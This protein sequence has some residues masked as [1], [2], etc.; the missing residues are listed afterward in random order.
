[1][2]REELLTTADVYKEKIRAYKGE[3]KE[4]IHT[5][6]IP[7]G[8][9]SEAYQYMLEQAQSSK[10]EITEALLKNFYGLCSPIEEVRREVLMSTEIESS[11]M[12]SYRTVALQPEWAKHTP[13]APG[14]LDHYM[15]HFMGQMQISRQMFHPIEFA[16]ICYKRILEICPFETGNEAVALL[17]LNLLL[18]GNGYEGIASFKDRELDYWSKLI[19]AQH[20]SQPDIDG[21]IAFVANYV[22]DIEKEK[23]C[24]LGIC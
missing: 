24:K 6:T 14:D 10:L 12:C 16:A 2:T 7:E 4:D 5:V 8:V 23:C 21:F 15:K 11:E 17:V 19:K 13:P 18:I 22:V 9:T 1:M 3:I 20:P